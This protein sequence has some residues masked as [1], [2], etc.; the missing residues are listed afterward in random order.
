MKLIIDISEESYEQAVRDKDYHDATGLD[1]INDYSLVIAQGIP[2]EERPH[3]EWIIDG[4]H[5]R[6]NR[7]NEY[8]C[9]TDREGNK[10]PDNF[11]SNCG[12]DMRKTESARPDTFGCF[13]CRHNGKRVTEY[14]CITCGV[15]YKNWVDYQEE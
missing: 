3:G 15:E 6:C 4:H 2:Y 10:I 12:A 7:C 8:I 13:N 1:D 5:I 9:N 11:C 14:P